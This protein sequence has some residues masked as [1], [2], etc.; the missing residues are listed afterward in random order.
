MNTDRVS[1]QTS[2]NS[3]MHDV[4]RLAGVNKTHVI[5]LVGPGGLAPL[6]WFC[7]HGYEQVGYVTEGSCLSEPCDLLIVL[8]CADAETLTR[9]LENGPQVQSGGVL[10]AQDPVVA[11][12]GGAESLDHMLSRHGRRVGGRIHVGGH[13]LFV[14]RSE[15]SQPVKQAA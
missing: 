2:F 1:R 15:A 12:T 13:E 14:I 7:R 3:A 11:S 8:R 10:I 6:L 5:R 4:V 9:L